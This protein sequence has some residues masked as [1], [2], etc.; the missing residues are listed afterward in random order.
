MQ[1]FCRSFFILDYAAHIYLIHNVSAF[2]LII[3]C[4]DIQLYFTCGRSTLCRFL[5]LT[6]ITDV[7]SILLLCSIFVKTVWSFN[8]FFCVDQLIILTSV[9]F[10]FHIPFCYPPSVFGSCDA[11][12]HHILISH[13]HSVLS[14]SDSAIS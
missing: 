3:E 13:I 14:L 5:L 1:I 6:S 11:S 10:T 4:T 9:A 2:V 7:H 12:T 8:S